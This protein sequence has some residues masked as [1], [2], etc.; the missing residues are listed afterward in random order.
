MGK[1]DSF[2][3]HEKIDNNLGVLE[4]IFSSKYSIIISKKIEDVM[5]N[6]W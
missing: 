1:S 2:T 6:L 3:H 5:K 4:P